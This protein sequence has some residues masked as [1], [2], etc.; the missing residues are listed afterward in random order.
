M[1]DPVLKLTV[2]ESPDQKSTITFNDIA[3]KL[4]NDKFLL[5]A[6]EFH[7]ELIESGREVKQLKEFFSNPSNFEQHLQPELS[8]SIRKNIFVLCYLFLFKCF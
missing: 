1:T 2:T 8:T 6:L 3:S 7:T 4:L 5:T